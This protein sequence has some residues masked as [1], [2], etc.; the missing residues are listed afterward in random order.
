MKNKL[1]PWKK[2]DLQLEPQWDEHPF[3]MLHRE[4]NALFNNFFQS[5]ELLS[6]PFGSASGFE[7]S[8]TDEKIRVKAELPGLEEKDIQISVQENV[9]TIRGEHREEKK[10]NKRKVHVSKMHYGSYSRTFP[11][12]AEVDAS[13]AKARLKHGV[14]TLDL[15]KTEQAKARSKRIPVSVD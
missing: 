7:V 11:L 5:P 13:N 14:L 4:V 10:E 1:I 8:E 12:P 15:P 9:L 3:D 2:R 6:K